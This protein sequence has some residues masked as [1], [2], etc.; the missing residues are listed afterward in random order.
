MFHY[1][2]GWMMSR[3]IQVLP[4]QVS[5]TIAAGEVVERPASIVKELVENAIDAGSSTIGVELES[6]GLRLVRVCD[7]GEGIDPDDVPLSLQRYATSKLKSTEDL[8]AIRTLGFRGEA[9]PSIASVTRMVIKTR[10][11]DSISGTKVVCQGGE[12]KSISEAG[13]PVGTEVEVK[14]LFYN[15]P[16]K[17]KFLKSIQTE[18]RHSLSHF[19]RLSLSYPSITFRFIHDGKM[20]HEFVKTDSPLVRMEAVLGREIYEHL[21]PFECEDREIKVSGFGSLPSFSKGNG[22]GIFI[23]VNRRYIKDR[24]IY[25]A[26][27]EAYRHVIP[28]GRFPVVVLFI[29]LPPS[30]VDVNVHP[31]KAEVKFRDQ[32]RIFRA[33][34]GALRSVHEQGLPGAF[35]ASRERERIPGSSETRPVFLP[36]YP[37]SEA[38]EIPVVREGP[39]SEWEPV[40]VPALDSGARGGLPFRILGQVQGTYIVCEGEE[41]LLFIDQH[42][43]HE[44]LLFEKYKKEYETGSIASERF[45]IPIAMELS[46]EESFIMASHLEEFESMGFEVDPLGE[47]TYALRCVPSFVDQ[48]NPKEILRKILEELSSLKKDGRGTEAIHAMLITLACHSAIRGNFIL[49]REEMEGLVQD[50]HPLNLSTTCPHGRPVFFVLPHYELSKQFRRKPSS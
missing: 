45:L 22:D 42:A 4:K 41:E 46:A 50:L 26:V 25:R 18:V 2:S 7:N 34:I 49:R 9:L 5:Q 48:K 15:I 16:V 20:I 3:K 23:Y 10:V 32:E 13:G 19:L 21:R 35:P 8:Y 24:M 27:V 43:A 40:R 47:K 14:D 36:F 6:G 37:R 30:A 44:R 31:A 11:R 29:D 28:A 38:Q 1:S 17:R 12:I 39:G 33:V